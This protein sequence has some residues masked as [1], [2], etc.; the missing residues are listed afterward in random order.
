MLKPQEWD[1]VIDSIAT[2]NTVLCVGAEL[3]SKDGLSLEKQ[4][5]AELEGLD[6]VSLY[7]DGLF[8]FKG[9]G[10]MI[11]YT[12]IKQFFNRPFPDLETILGQFADLPIPLVVNATPDPLLKR[13]YAQKNL[14][15]RYDYHHPN[16]PAGEMDPLTVEEPLL[17]NLMGDLLQRESMI[18]THEDLFAFIESLME[19]KSVP[20]VLKERINTAYNFLFV[21]LPFDRWYMKVL[22]HFL[23]KDAK[24]NAMK[25]AANAALDEEVQSF[26]V[27]QFQI[28]CV[29]V[30]IADFSTELYR[31]CAE[32]G[33]LR[34]TAPTPKMS[35]YERWM[36]MVAD[37]Q[38]DALLDQLVAH[39][40]EHVAQDQ[41][42]LTTL[43]NL[44]GRL[45]NLEKIVQRG[46]VAHDAAQLQRNQIRDAILNFL[47]DTVK[48]LSV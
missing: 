6:N 41:E 7:A 10:D 18:L 40:T 48:S 5:G 12:K 47:Q 29:P 42:S 24:S 34:S 43:F 9:A 45:N 26:M 27:D 21:G 2:G 46:T 33:I 1:S 44:S 11:S 4:I 31:R 28:T 39:F 20:R 16:K 30:Q 19:G 37:D 35:Q 14:P 13:A 17:Y 25:Y 15:F 23:Q 8:H 22:L 38:L 3:F 36:R 32:R